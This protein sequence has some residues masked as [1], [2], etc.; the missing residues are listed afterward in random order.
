MRI[1]A[2]A[3]Q[4]G[5]VG[6]TTTA[7]NLGAA[8]HQAGANVLL[9]DSDPQAHL[10]YHMGLVPSADS[11]VG[12]LNPKGKTSAYYQIE[13]A[14]G[15]LRPA[16]LY[17]GL[18]L[19]GVE[20]E[21]AGV[22]GKEFILRERL[23]AHLEREKQKPDYILIDCPPSLGPLTIGALTAADEVLVPMTAEGLPLNGLAQLLDAIE[24]VKHR[25][26]KRLR[27]AGVVLTRYD[28]RKRLAQGVADALA[29]RPE[30]AV[31][32]TRIRE[33]IALAEAPTHGH[34][35]LEYAPTSHGAQDYEA[36]AIEAPQRFA[37]KGGRNA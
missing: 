34:T 18:E 17:S 29:K 37:W 35:I 9:I 13:P 36:L 10:T 15:H 1:I 33:N 19:A 12:F 30:I 3:S 7:V 23:E 26:N 2:L 31:F 11:L 27:V 16:V 20:M 8:L 28:G 6:K 21:M 5:G 25:L 22:A 32:E 14:K 4:K 24:L